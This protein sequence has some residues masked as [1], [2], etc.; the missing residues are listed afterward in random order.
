M[1]VRRPG[2]RVGSWLNYV[3][4]AG[5]LLLALGAWLHLRGKLPEAAQFTP[6]AHRLQALVGRP[7]GEGQ[8]PTAGKP[9]APPAKR[10]IAAYGAL[11]LAFEA[12]QGQTDRRVKYLA[13]GPGY[14]VF[15]TAREAIF[16]LAAPAP[17]PKQERH[18][19]NLRRR[20]SRDSAELALVRMCLDGAAAHP[21]T[22]P[23]E[24]LPGVSNYFLGKDPQHWQRSVPH[25]ASVRYLQ[26]YP[27][28]DMLFHG[29]RRQLEFDF[30][31][32]PGAATSPIRLRFWGARQLTTNPSGDL[33]LASAA[34]QLRLHKP[35]AYQE[36]EGVRHLVEARFVLHR[37]HQ[38]TLAFGR[39]DHGRELVIDPVLSYSTL[40][41]GSAQDDATAIAVDSSGHA[42]VTGDT[43]SPNFP[44]ASATV[45]AKANLD[46]FVSQIEADGSALNYTTL[47]GGSGD[48]TGNSIA[49]DGSGNAYIAGTTSSPDFPVTAGVLGA[50]RQ[51][52]LDAFALKLNSS[53]NITYA[54]YLGGSDAD[55]GNSIAVDSNGDAYVGGE[56][57][58]NDFPGASDSTIQANNAGFDDGFVAELNPAATALI[59]STYLGGSA[60]DLVTGM[61]LDASNNIYA[62]GVTLSSD[63]PHTSGA[64]QTR[65][66][67]DG[68]CNGGLDDAFVAEIKAGGSVLLYSTYLGG[69][70]TDDANAI[71][72]DAAGETYVAGLTTSGDFPTAAPAQKANAG[73][74]DAFVAKLNAQGSG[75]I[76]ST[77]LGGT[78]NDEATAIALDPLGDAYVTGRTFS[79][80]GFPTMS[81]FQAANGG[82][83]D[84]FITELSNTGGLVYSSYLGGKGNENSFQGSVA[85]SALGGVAVD[86]AGS[87][88]VAGNTNSTSGFPTASPL[89]ASNGG[90]VTDAFVAKVGAAAA[91]FSISAGDGSVSLLAGSSAQVALAVNS[92]NS[93]FS[94]AVTLSCSGLPAGASCGF[95]PPSGTPAGDGFNSTLTFSTTSAAKAGNYT[96]T[97][98]GS[99][100]AATHAATVSLKVE[101]FQ[102]TASALAPASIAAGSSSTSSV[103]VAPANGFAGDVSLSCG[104]GMP[105]GVSCSFSPAKITGGSGHSTLTVNTTSSAAAGAVNVTVEGTS[106]SDDHSVSLNLTL[107]TAPDFTIAA[108]PLSPASVSAGGSATSTLTISPAGGFSSDVELSCTSIT[109]AA[110]PPPQCAFSTAT[111]TGG[112]GTSTLTVSTTGPLALRGIPPAPRWGAL[113]A[114]L[115]P[116]A[117][118][119]LVG[120]GIGKRKKRL[121]SFFLAL[122]AVTA[123]FLLPSCSGSSNGGLKSADPGTPPNNY[124]IVVTGSANSGALTHTAS[125][126]LTVQ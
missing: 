40:L 26:V 64:F 20:S 88:Y 120:A 75:L 43:A 14:S 69:S 33:V 86:S 52:A 60:A 50:S 110:A 74:P 18:A 122:M 70:G 6:V 97:V 35:A 78:S 44:G 4:V 92:L 111:V 93:P 63:F 115:L 90:G 19:E 16:S 65:C 66:G 124:T 104:S 49:V 59:Y 67:T 116:I 5:V 121:A 27:G 3:P 30:V 10:L 31:V 81:A 28:V 117:G 118:L 37:H 15:L 17:A 9:V 1:S 119:A 57:F 72:V 83:A 29:G 55:S 8:L 39:Y 105:T 46:V 114:V 85:Q 42:Y 102:L 53:G 36:Q 108:T 68:A 109:P 22:L 51:G 107:Q 34:G 103:T 96:I 95:S 106:G 101:N 79:T 38:V 100:G 87:A 84:A 73:A 23:G 98:S 77:Y 80:A 24:P 76:F 71:A 94:S 56:T 62:T 82:G 11:P 48:E 126:S 91:D 47:I 21:H 112:Q 125:V 13:H 54:T 113:Y 32:A 89:Q 99:A 25:Y 2:P 58:S 41:G 45:S 123:L 12:N 7:G 61:A